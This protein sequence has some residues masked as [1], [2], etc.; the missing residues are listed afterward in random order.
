MTWIALVVAGLKASIVCMVFAVGLSAQ[1]RQALFLFVHPGRLLRMLLAMHLIMPLLVIATLAA[2]PAA[3][4]LAL[5]IKIALLALAASP[6][7]PILTVK[8]PRAGGRSEYIVGLLVSNCLLAVLIVPLS[9]ALGE[10]LLGRPAQIAPLGIVLR[11]LVTVLLP[12]LAGS[13]VHVLAPRLARSA[14]RPV[15]V[16]SVALLLATAVPVLLRSWPAIVQMTG[17]G[18]LLAFAAFVATGLLVGHLLGGPEPENRVV[19]GL[20]TA[21]R[22]PGIAVALA[23]SAFPA[24]KLVVPAVLAYLLVGALVSTA[25]LKGLKHIGASSPAAIRRAAGSAR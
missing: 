21:S 5:P 19:L 16:A 12:L 25:Y 13:A 3:G 10:R 22:H 24:E 9:L 4:S 8:G 14:A 20:A 11:M 6:V 7:P 2:L 17:N 18:M 23:H 15:L 1:P